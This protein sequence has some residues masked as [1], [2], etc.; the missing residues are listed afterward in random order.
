MFDTIKEIYEYRE[1]LRNLVNRDLRT[2]YKG[3]VLGFLWTF[4]NP[5]LQLAIFS[6]IFSF[7]MR[8]QIDNYTAFLFV[9]LLPWFYFAT[10]TSMANGLIIG[11]AS[12]IKKIYFPRLILPLSAAVAGL[13][14]LI[15]SLLVAIPALLFMGCQPFTPSLAVLPVILLL[16]GILVLGMVMLISALNVYFRD[17]EHIWNV[18]LL[19]WMYFTPV[20]YP[21]SMVPAEYRN[22]LYINPM[23]AL[24]LLYRDVLFYGQI[25]DPELFVQAF[26]WAAGIAVAG[27]LV[28]QKLSRRFAEE[29]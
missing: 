3:S 13:I 29:I 15:L 1:L 28:F 5:L 11:Q 20:L 14:N 24:T 2:R 18:L 25:S 16:Q 8:I 9:A 12:I 22:L 26:L 6:V 10:T 17:L 23:T 7:I 21:L 19:G 27:F 4:L